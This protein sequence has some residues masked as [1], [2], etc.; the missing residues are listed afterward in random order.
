MTLDKH[1]RNHEFGKKNTTS[2]HSG[3]HRISLVTDSYGNGAGSGGGSGTSQQYSCHFCAK[4]FHDRRHYD[5]H[6]NTHA[7]AKP[8]Q[9]V[10]CRKT[11]AYKNNLARHTKKCP[12]YQQTLTCF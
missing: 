6:M 8:H 7:G 12:V 4:S 9:C 1:P 10:G 5:G 11:F 2:Q 3:E